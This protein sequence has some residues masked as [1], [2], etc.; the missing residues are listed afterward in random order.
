[1]KPVITAL[2]LLLASTLAHA[3]DFTE[4]PQKPVSIGD[5]WTFKRVA[6]GQITVQ[7]RII[8]KIAQQGPDKQ[9]VIQTLPG[10]V[11]GK[12]A[13]A[14]RNAG[15]VD[16]DACMIDFFGG[17]TLGITNSCNTAFVPGMDWNT[18]ET[19]KGTRTTQRYQVIGPEEVTVGAG[20]F[21]AIKIE[22]HWE[23]AKVLNPG[24]T[25]LKYGAPLR[26]HF[27]YWYAPETKTMVKTEREFRNSAGAVD[28]RSTDELQAFRVHKPG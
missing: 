26:Y 25:P 18:E 7:S 8:F 14:W 12:G 1:M 17:G 28:T 15:R 19:D 4:A 3:T 23:V 6:T 24:K 11:S 20:S 27:F 21:M 22:S 16:M 13:I 10:E 2:A 5:S 9:F